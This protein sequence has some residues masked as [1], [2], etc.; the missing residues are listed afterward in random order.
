MA[1]EDGED[2]RWWMPYAKCIGLPADFFFP[3]V[4]DA[5]GN[6]VMDGNDGASEKPDLG[7]VKRAKRFCRGLDPLTG[8]KI[9][10]EECPVREECLHYSIWIEQWDGVFGGMVERERRK[11]SQDL[12][13]R[14]GFGGGVPSPARVREVRVTVTRKRS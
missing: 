6:V 3:V 7:G 1:N 10:G 9:P 5:N 13:S 2:I 8:A 14:I 12:K 4:K 11:Y